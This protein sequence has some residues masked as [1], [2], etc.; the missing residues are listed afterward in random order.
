[1]FNKSSKNELSQNNG[2]LK[3][4]RHQ[5]KWKWRQRATNSLLSQTQQPS[6]SPLVS[7]A[8]SVRTYACGSQMPTTD[9]LLM[10]KL[11]VTAWR[12]FYLVT[13]AS[14]RVCLLSDG[15]RQADRFG[16][17]NTATAT[18]RR[19][20]TDGQTDGP[21]SAD[22]RRGFSIISRRRRTPSQLHRHHLPTH[23]P[24]M[25]STRS[26]LYVY[27]AAAAA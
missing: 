4:S 26:S 20:R 22:W 2:F 5:R 17:E 25:F 14:A 7:V 15:R 3:L 24:G 13:L 6:S 12:K 19:K 11:L 18:S 23:N 21:T 10:I 27:T 8:P 9:A 16:N 1:M